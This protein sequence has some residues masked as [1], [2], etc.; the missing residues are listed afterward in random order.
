M[1]NFH[2]RK[3]VLIV[4]LLMFMCFGGVA[5]ANTSAFEKP[6]QEGNYFYTVEDG[7]ATIVWYV[8]SDSKVIIPDILGGFPVTKIGEQSFADSDNIVTVKMSDSINEIGPKAFIGCSALKDIT[9]PDNISIIGEATF[10]FCPELE[11]VVLPKNLTSI[12]DGA[13]A[14]CHKLD[15]VIIP[16][17]VTSI[18]EEAF[19]KCEGLTSITIPEGV[20]NLG[21]L[22]FYGCTSLIDVVIEEGLPSIQK[23]AFTY[24][25][26]L[27]NILIKS[28]TTEIFDEDTTIPST[29]KI[30][31]SIDSNAKLYSDKYDRQF[32]VWIDSE[33]MNEIPIKHDVSL[34]K[35]WTITFSKNVSPN[36]INEDN[37]YI[38][39][40]GGEKI[41]V[42]VTQGDTKEKV[43]VT[44]KALYQPEKE[45]ILFVSNKVKSEDQ[46][47]EI[48]KGVAMRFVTT[49]SSQ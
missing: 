11:N 17:S 41:P 32:E 20:N 24:C 43:V 18:G 8:G 23:M 10:S 14:I 44:P 36:S 9:L 49:N 12:G 40:T 6:I 1:S 31:A 38:T 33:L 3:W 47:L 5:S 4:T 34:N 16:P 39:D 13:F 37:F 25:S 15:G 28:A 30:I 48:S 42:V 19:F 22:A 21:A 45:Y 35:S 29:T 46:G 26:N 27:K 2:K 7:E